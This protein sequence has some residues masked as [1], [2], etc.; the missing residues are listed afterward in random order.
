MPHFSRIS[1][2]GSGSCGMTSYNPILH[3]GLW[4]GVSIYVELEYSR[5][6]TSTPIPHATMTI[7]GV[8]HST[9]LWRRLYM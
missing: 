5:Y 4:G 2:R 6:L 9:T 3:Y 1:I 7:A 8:L